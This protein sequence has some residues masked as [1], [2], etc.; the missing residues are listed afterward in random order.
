[1]TPGKAEEQALA[2][3]SESFLAVTSIPNW[4]VFFVPHHQEPCMFVDPSP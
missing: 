2:L 4:H 3:V 1:M